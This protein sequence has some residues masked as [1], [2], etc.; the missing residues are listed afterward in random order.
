M[1]RQTTIVTRLLDKMKSLHKT[2]KIAKVLLLQTH[3]LHIRQK[4]KAFPKFVM[5]KT[6]AS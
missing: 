5:A 2:S 6:T 1:K 4:L 3:Y